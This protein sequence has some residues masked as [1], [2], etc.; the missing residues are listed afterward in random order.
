MAAHATRHREM[1]EAEQ[2]LR[3]A[4]TGDHYEH[5]LVAFAEALVLVSRDVPVST[6]ADYP[7]WLPGMAHAPACPPR[8]EEKAA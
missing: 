5:D 6:D 3:A 1:S 8:E 4:M 2:V 7:G